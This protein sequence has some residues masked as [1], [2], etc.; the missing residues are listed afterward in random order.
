MTG[1]VSALLQ[2]RWTLLLLLGGLIAL[3][4]F[5][6]PQRRDRVVARDGSSSWESSSA[7]PRREIVWSPAT[8]IKEI[9]RNFPAGDFL[10]PHLTDNGS[11]LYFAFRKHGR[12]ADL[13]ISRFQNG[14]WQR[15]TKVDALCS[16][17][18][19]LGA[20]FSRDGQQVFFV[21][22]RAGGL[23]GYDL[24]TATRV[25]D[26]WSQPRNLGK[27]INTKAN[28][29]DPALS[30]DGLALYFASNRSD[31][32]LDL[33]RATRKNARTSWSDPEP[34]TEINQLASHERAPF[35]AGSGKYLYFASNRK[36]GKG[37]EPNFDLYRARIGERIT[38]IENL[39]SSINSPAD[40]TES[41]LSPEG[42]RLLFAS[43]RDGN[44]L[45][46][47]SSAQEVVVE[48]QWDESRWL[49]CPQWW[50]KVLLIAITSVTLL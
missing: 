18:N 28:E 35:V 39:G 38:D 26:G 17:A 42:F 41:S 8:V 27:K 4:L 10:T 6:M 12:S 29:H 9:Q 14:R 24:Y 36:Q 47:Q 43:N 1:K 32:Q 33:Y 15:P 21:S 16:S 5:V 31:E 2:S 3:I 50:W 37:I 49:L 20:T 45:I 44:G 19:D 34:L 30:P 40:E 7:P 22:D 25:K 13:F 23:G 46:Y 11:A 48:T